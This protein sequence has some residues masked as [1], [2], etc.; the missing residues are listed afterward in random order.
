M[1]ILYMKKEGKK[2]EIKTMTI[3]R[4]VWKRLYNL[5]GDNEYRS[6]SDLIEDLLDGKLKK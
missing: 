3:K 4:R 6:M 2:E 5:K 1:T